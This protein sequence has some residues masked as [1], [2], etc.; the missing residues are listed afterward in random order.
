[1]AL[2]NNEARR[3]QRK[4]EP[5]QH[6]LEMGGLSEAGL[7]RLH[8]AMS[9]MFHAT[10]CQVWSRPS[11]GVGQNIWMLSALRVDRTVPMRSDTIFR[12]ASVTKL[13]TAVATIILV[14]E[15]RLR[16]DDRST[17]SCRNWQPESSA[18][19]R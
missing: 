2:Q 1:M 13:I 5:H 17:S 12:M 4:A 14:E 15:C 10:N 16:L 19:H 6:R 11:A 18:D 8:N 9:G 7:A 3:S